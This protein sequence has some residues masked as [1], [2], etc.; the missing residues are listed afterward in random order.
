MYQQY[1]IPFEYKDHE[2]ICLSIQKE[3]NFFLYHRI[4][5]EEEFEKVLALNEGEVIIE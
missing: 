1:E 3:G 2:D 5:L 4:C